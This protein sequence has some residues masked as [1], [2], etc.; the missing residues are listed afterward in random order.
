VWYDRNG[1]AI[2]T[3]GTPA[4]YADI[5]L[6]P[7]GTR[8]LVSIPRPNTVERDLW[9][10]DVT[11]RVRTRFTFD[12]VR[13]RHG[14]IWSPDGTQ[15]VFASERNGRVALVRRAADGSG[16]E[17]VL[18]VDEFDKELAS[19]SP[20]GRFLL[21]NVRQGGAPPSPWVLSL[22]GERKPTPFSQ[23]R[24]FLPTF[25][26]DG[27]WVAYISPESGRNEVYVTAFPGPGRKVQVSATGGIDPTWSVNGKEIFYLGGGSLMSASVTLQRDAVAIG[28]VKPL[29]DLAKVGPRKAHDI[30]RD[31]QRIIAVTQDLAA[32]SSPLTLVVNWQALLKQ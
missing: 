4:E 9:I 19:W 18:L 7:D 23:P 20:D 31:G 24:A 5:Q 29:F 25:S 1:R 3:L 15:I 14:A 27:H 12:D 32:A 22:D 8:A 6:S 30:S 17:E 10:F 16:A 28:P 21:Y 13:L 11:R 26:P 2:G